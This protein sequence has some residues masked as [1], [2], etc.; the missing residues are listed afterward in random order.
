M[1]IGASSG[2]VSPS[3]ADAATPSAAATAAVAGPRLHAER[4]SRS[5]LAWWCARARWCRC[6]LGA[7]DAGRGGGGGGRRRLRRAG[8]IACPGAVAALGLV[9]A[10]AA[11]G[12]EERGRPA[13]SRG[14]SG[15][16]WLPS[17]PGRPF[18]RQGTRWERLSLVLNPR[19]RG[20]TRHVARGSGGGRGGGAREGAIGDAAGVCWPPRP[21][22]GA[23]AE[24][25]A[26]STSGLVASRVAAAGARCGSRVQP[27]RSRERCGAPH[28]LAPRGG[29]RGDLRWRRQR[30]LNDGNPP[31]PAA[32]AWCVSRVSRQRRRRWARAAEEGAGTVAEAAAGV[33][34]GCGAARRTRAGAHPRRARAWGQRSAP[35]AARGHV[36]T[37]TNT[38]WLLWAGRRSC[39]PPSE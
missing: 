23:A 3:P 22:R 30:P 35:A 7:A 19:R 36:A 25:T 29:A 26:S 31:A 16:G 20:L 14:R 1:S 34:A 8:L 4:R 21:M 33:A 17:V 18:E 15:G 11:T 28:P 12:G 9:R 6:T 38:V 39:R 13:M 24:A 5:I 10:A 2:P 37:P 27:R 32:V